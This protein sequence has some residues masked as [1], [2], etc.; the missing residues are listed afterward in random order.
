[1]NDIL[2]FVVSIYGKKISDYLNLDCLEKNITISF[3]ADSEEL[4]DSIESEKENL[5]RYNSKFDAGAFKVKIIQDYSIK[6]EETPISDLSYCVVED[7]KFIKI[8]TPFTK[9]RAYDFLLGKSE[10]MPKILRILK[11]RE[12]NKNFSFND[13]VP[14]IGFDFQEIESETIKFLM[15][16]EFRE[17]CSSK[18]IKLKRGIILEG[19]PGT[20]KTLTLQWLR[21]QA[22]KNNIS[23][24]QFKSVKEFV[25]SIDEYYES[26]KKIFVFED[27]DAALK[28][29]TDTGDA[30][31]QILATVLNTLE[32]VEEINDVVSIFTTNNIDVFDRAFIRPGRIDRVFK[33]E[34]P[35][36]KDY[37]DF[38][39][40][41]VPDEKEPVDEMVEHL[42]FLSV[43]ISYA[44]LKGICDDINIFKFSGKSLT[45]KEIF[46]IIK[47][48]V[49]GANKDKNVNN[50][51]NYIL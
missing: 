8:V 31:N 22:E 6:E 44:I 37:L 45:I 9:E 42:S 32:G 50:T 39:K 10:E 43:D 21:N 26:S 3:F 35:T 48:K 40:A 41:Y 17:Y 33:Y 19:K 29:R 18:F 20:G 12:A 36:K 27:F 5:L 46:D 23:Y 47:Q 49:T 1:M 4:V 34:L 24:R 11:E 25:E 2:D 38:F 15:N 30:P 13:N 14:I 16:D 28:E 51:K 7:F